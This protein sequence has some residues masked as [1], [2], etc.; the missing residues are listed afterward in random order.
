M[1]R[2]SFFG[3]ALLGLVAG[4][5]ASARAA[6]LVTVELF[7]SQGCASCPAADA[8][9]S[10]LADRPDVLALTFPV[11]YWDYLGWRDTL[12]EP[13]FTKRQYAYA[14][15][16]RIGSPYT[17]QMVIDGR[18]D[19]VGNQEAKI[20]WAIADEQKRAGLGPEITVT[21]EGQGVAVAIGAA[22]ASDGENALK[23]D[24]TVWLV[25]YA[26]K[27]V[28]K[29]GRGENEDRTLTYRHVVRALMPVGMWNGTAARIVLPRADLMSA[30]QDQAFAVIVQ[31]SNTGPILSAARLTL[32]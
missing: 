23:G 28:V 11:D 2:I 18:I 8:L 26:D 13:E 32:P 15:A 19:V 6:G 30:P 10:T 31:A 9:L 7:T 14:K 16:L 3:L 1:R 20:G 17:P 21:S 29:V 12:A 24:A 22:P 27:A 5:G 4:Y 25:R